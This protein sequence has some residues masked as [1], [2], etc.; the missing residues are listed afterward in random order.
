MAKIAMSK[1]VA[2]AATEAASTSTTPAKAGDVKAKTPKLPKEVTPPKFISI[3][4]FDGHHM[5][6]AEYQDY[7]FSIND[8]KDRRLTDTE[9]C[10]DWQ[11]QFPHAVIYEPKHV[12]GARRDYNQGK[13][14]KAFPNYKDPQSQAWFIDPVTGAKTQTAPAKV[15]AEPTAKAPAKAKKETAAPKAESPKIKA[16]RKK[17]AA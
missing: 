2:A 5:R 17:T 3:G 8:R 16:A 13:H 6:V 12:V 10:A 14:S 1:K 11:A 9:L 15:T 7:T 4:M